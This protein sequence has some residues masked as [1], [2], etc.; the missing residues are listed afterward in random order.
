MIIAFDGR[1][2]RAN[3]AAAERMVDEAIDDR[4]MISMFKEIFRNCEAFQFT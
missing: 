4:I 1:I 3:A 2:T